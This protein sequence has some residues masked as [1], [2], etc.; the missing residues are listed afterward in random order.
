M[1]INYINKLLSEGYK[2]EDVRKK[3]E[4]G[5]KNFQRN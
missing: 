5:E 2:V 1:D 4:I 3:L